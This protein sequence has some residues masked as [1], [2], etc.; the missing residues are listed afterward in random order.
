VDVQLYIRVL[1]RFRV[2]VAT[3]L[4]LAVALT[5]FTVARVSFSGGPK[6]SYRGQEQWMGVARLFVTQEGFPW[7]RAIV[8]SPSSQPGR[9]APA[10]KPVFAAPERLASLAEL[11]AQLATTDAVA[12]LAFGRGQPRP[13][14]TAEPIR[15]VNGFALP[16]I[17]VLVTAPSDREG[18][19]LARRAAAALRKY[20]AR[21]QNRS[22]IPARERIVLEIV[23]KPKQAILIQGRSFVRPLMVFAAVML[24][25]VALAFVLENLRPAVRPL[26]VATDVPERRTA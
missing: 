17:D 6:L 1:W 3:G 2:L 4:V 15:G 7:G 26:A 11:Y 22:E 24:L 9:P 23:K 25:V 5:F 18:V 8:A 16:L 21:E 14:I 13:T 12:R 20:V 19:L 10:D